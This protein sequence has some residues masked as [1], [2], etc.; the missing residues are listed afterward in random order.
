MPTMRRA[1]ST[2]VPLLAAVL[3]VAATGGVTLAG[4]GD[5]DDDKGD[6]RTKGQQEVTAPPAVI[7]T[8]DGDQVKM[9][10]TKVARSVTRIADAAG[11]QV[12]SDGAP[13]PDAEAWTD[14]RSVHLAPIKVPG[15]LVARLFEDFPRG[16]KGTFYGADADW[17]RDD[18]AVFVAIELADRLPSEPVIQQVEV[19][20][21]GD[22]AGP[23]QVGAATDTR[24]GLERFSLSGTFRDGSESSGTTDVSGRLPGEPIDYYDARIGRLRLPRCTRPVPTT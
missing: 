20:L 21:D 18:R 14:I 7:A 12:L 9:A 17:S 6:K 23:L 10:R 3:L 8:V 16:A 24:A 5:K 13:A 2:A 19:G 15:K 4:K 11:D 22:A 1:L